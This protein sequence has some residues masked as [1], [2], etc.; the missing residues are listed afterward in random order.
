[1]EVRLHTVK[2][3]SRCS[4][5][6]ITATTAVFAPTLVQEFSAADVHYM[7]MALDEARAAA[8]EGEV[9]VGAVLVHGDRILARGHNRVHR[10]R[11]PVAHAEMLCITAGASKLSSWRL[12]GATLYAT[13]EPCPM[14]AGAI[15]QA[16][17][18]RVVYGCKARHRAEATHA[19]EPSLGIS[20]A[21]RSTPRPADPRAPSYTHASDRAGTDP[22]IA[23]RGLA[24]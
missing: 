4:T 11:S 20:S 21:T 10:L 14:C 7:G 18:A 13:L 5:P 2:T 9:P 22:L 24:I 15:L 16:R 6:S 8:A 17:I 12:L 3:S 1:R 19:A 23:I